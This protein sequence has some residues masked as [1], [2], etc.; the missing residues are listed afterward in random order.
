MAQLTWVMLGLRLQTSQGGMGA[1]GM[2]SVRARV[3]AA[4][5]SLLLKLSPYSGPG[6]YLLHDQHWL[7]SSL[8]TKKKKKVNGF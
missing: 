8:A 7:N 5:D 2:L 1:G 4:A 3:G 6:A